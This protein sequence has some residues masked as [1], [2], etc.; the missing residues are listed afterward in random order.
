MDFYDIRDKEFPRLNS[1]TFL[2]AACVSLVP[3]R[4]AKAQKDFIDH[5]TDCIEVSSSAH[6]VAM[7]EKRTKAYIEGAKLL[8]ADIEEIALI[9]STTHALNIAATSLK[10]PKGSKVLTTSLE[11]L[12]VAMPWCMMKD[13]SVEVVPGRNGMFETIDFVNAIDGKTKLIVVSSVEWC[14]GWRVDLKELS[15][16]CR[17]NNIYLVSDSVHHLGTLDLNVKEM[18]IDII[19]AGG[20]KWLNSPFGC[21]LIYI[22]KR[23]IDKIDPAFWGYLNLETPEGGWPAYFANPNIKPINNWKFINTAKKFEIGGTS[24]YLGA[25]ALGESLEL[26]NEL[27]IKNIENHNIEL[28]D[29]CVN[30]LEKIGATIITHT[31]VDRKHRSS[32]VNFRFYQDMNEENQLLNELHNRG[33]YLAMRFTSN[34]GGMRVSCHYFNNK[35]DIDHLVSVLKDIAKTK[36]P[37]FKQ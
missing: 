34:I 6:H 35:K 18:D 33:I 3:Q 26:I 11:F 13:I 8:N 14:N 28:A 5:C 24:N 25:I 22:N 27:D 15:K 21:G 30:E 37:D 7:D 10:L 32:L 23:I 17:S 19:T 12:Q 2:D 4:A 20:H 29:Y 1:K 31:K 36:A 16:L 9:E